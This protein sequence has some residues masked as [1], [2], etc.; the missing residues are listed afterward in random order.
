MKPALL[1]A[2]GMAAVAARAAGH[3]SRYEYTATAADYPLVRDVLTV[4][5]RRG[6]D[7]IVSEPRSD[8]EQGQVEHHVWRFRGG[9]EVTLTWT[10]PLPGRQPKLEPGTVSAIAADLGV[11]DLAAARAAKAAPDDA[12][13]LAEIRRRVV[14]CHACRRT[15][16]THSDAELR[17]CVAKL[18]S[19]EPQ[20]PGAS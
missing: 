14:W 3:R 9:G 17:A 16:K 8:G 11:I 15:N 10:N 4:A 12:A 18:S 6:A 13:F 19:S 2:I 1:H 5:L 7:E 20:P